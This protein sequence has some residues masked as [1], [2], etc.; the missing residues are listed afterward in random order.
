[1]T[2][3]ERLEKVEQELTAA[4]QINRWKLTAVVLAASLLCMV[5]KEGFFVT[6]ANAGDVDSISYDVGKIK[7][8]V[9]SIK[10][11][12]EDTNYIVRKIKKNMP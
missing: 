4:K 11:T 1:M 6:P 9:D 2:T 5:A 7:S 8:D 3:E 12:V 10:S